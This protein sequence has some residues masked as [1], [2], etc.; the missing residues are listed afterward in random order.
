MVE[1][2]MQ[3]DIA[4]T[5]T[6]EGKLVVIHNPRDNFKGGAFHYQKHSF[7]QMVIKQPPLEDKDLNTVLVAQISH[8]KIVTKPVEELGSESRNSLSDDDNEISPRDTDKLEPSV[9]Q[10]DSSQER[11]GPYS[12]IDNKRSEISIYSPKARKKD[13]KEAFIACFSTLDD[14]RKKTIVEHLRELMFERSHIAKAVDDDKTPSRVLPTIPEKHNNFLSQ[15]N[16]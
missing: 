6:G 2:K 15:L 1:N 5:S 3:Q 7:S 12:T 11:A 13:L 10:N 8:F 14:E 9:F 16:S 4:N